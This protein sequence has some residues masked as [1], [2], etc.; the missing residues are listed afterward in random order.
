MAIEAYFDRI[1][2][3]SINMEKYS[4]QWNSKFNHHNHLIS[5]LYSCVRAHSAKIASVAEKFIIIEY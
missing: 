4:N 2:I 3:I 1:V 5:K